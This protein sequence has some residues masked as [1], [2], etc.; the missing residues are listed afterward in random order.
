MC[1]ILAVLLQ[2]PKE[3]LKRNFEIT[4]AMQVLNPRGPDEQNVVNLNQLVMGHTRLSVVNP[5]SGQQP[6]RGEKYIVSVNAEIYNH[7]QISKCDVLRTP[8]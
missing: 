6:L 7:K 1:G 4:H 8:P 5:T 2:T 3:S